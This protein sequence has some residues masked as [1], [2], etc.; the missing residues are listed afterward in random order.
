MAYPLEYLPRLT[1]IA[2]GM[3]DVRVPG[4]VAH[5]EAERIARLALSLMTRERERIERP[6]MS[7]P[8]GTRKLG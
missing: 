6:Y 8:I 2:Y 1:R 5:K 4:D 3:L 7:R